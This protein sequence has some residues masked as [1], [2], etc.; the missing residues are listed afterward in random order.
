MLAEGIGRW[1]AE[2]NGEERSSS[3]GGS[4]SCAFVV[5]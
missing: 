2:R 4:E 5:F 1:R 3:R